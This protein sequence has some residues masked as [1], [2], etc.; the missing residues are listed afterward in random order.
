VANTLEIVIKGTDQASGTFDAITGRARGFSSGLQSSLRG[1]MVAGG[2]V[3]GA[4]AGIGVAAARAF[5]PT[6]E[7]AREFELAVVDMGIAADGTGLSLATLEDAAIAVGGDTSLL[8]V[9][10]SDAAEAI[11]GL[12]KA[13]LTSTEVF[14]DLQGYMAGTAELGGALRASIDLAA[15]TELDMVQASDLAAVA[16][17]TFG[18]ELETEE[19]RARFVEDAMNNL[20]Q[21][22]NA[23]V[24]SVS[25]L[26]ASMATAG[27]VFAMFGFD[28]EDTNNAL[29]ILSMRGI[30]GAE[31]GTALKSMLM[32]MTAQTDSTQE[33]WASLGLSM[34]DADGAMREL[35]DVIG[36]LNGAMADMTEEERNATMAALAGSYGIKA[37]STLLAEGEQGWRDMAQAT[38][39][40]MGITEQARLK[41]DTL[42]GAQEVLEGV[43][44]T[45]KIQ[46][47]QALLPALTT[48]AQT[49]AGLAEQYGPQ[50][51]AAMGAIGAWLGDNLP[52]VIA[53]AI[54]WFENLVASLTPVVAWIVAFVTE[55]GPMLQEAFIAI[56]AVLGAFLAAG[57][58]AAIAMAIAALVNPIGLIAAGIALLAVAWTRDW[59]G[60]R[61]TLTAFWNETAK[62]FIDNLV[63]WFQT[64]VPDA[65]A[66]V[67]D[68]FVTAWGNI[69]TA[70]QVV[71]Q[72]LVNIWNALST[73]F[74]VTIP[75]AGRSLWESLQRTLADIKEGFETVWNGIL[76]FLKSVWD[77]IR[78]AVLTAIILVLQLLGTNLDEIKAGWE[79][80]WNALRDH[81]TNI[82]NAIASTVETVFSAVKDFIGTTLDTLQST[83]ETVWGAV[84]AFADDTWDAIY[85]KASEIV[86]AVRAY[87]EEKVNAL[88][89]QWETAWGL[90]KDAAETAWNA[91]KTKVEEILPAIIAVVTEKAAELKAALIDPIIE[92]KDAI[93]EK[94]GEWAQLG[95]DLLEGLIGGVKEK[96]GG[97]IDSVKGAVGDAIQEAKNI[98]GIES[99]SKVF[100]EIGRNVVQ[101]MID[102]ILS[103]KGNLTSTINGLIDI[104]Q[105][106]GSLGGFAA[107][108]LKK[109]TVEPLAGTLEK[110]DERIAEMRE[111]LIESADAGDMYSWLAI[112]RELNTLLAERTR[113][114]EQFAEAEERVLRMEKQR[115]QLGFLQEQMKLLDFIKER[116]LDA[117]ALL[118]GVKLG[119]NADLGQII[120]VMSAAMQAVLESAENTLGIASPSKK[121][122]EIGRNIMQGLSHGIAGGAMQPIAD[123][124]MV[125][126]R[127]AQAAGTTVNNVYNLNANYAYQDERTLTQ[128][129][130]LLSM[131]GA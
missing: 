37:L 50:V 85:T 53:G 91:I 106:F 71:W 117:G 24:S 102:G 13:G 93:F 44:E 51:V 80:I 15:A 30:K 18:G 67:R 82:W 123:V 52:G 74:T 112:Q 57:S 113:L 31:A 47:G 84:S 55:H 14:A 87:V 27:P 76:G 94:V 108:L 122:A 86:E 116:G 107:S 98:L 5:G 36:D 109:R 95:R 119:I 9:T 79:F 103:G 114:G 124:A 28:L 64:T 125:G 38:A 40:A 4:I 6:I 34:Y 81:V 48:L 54:A 41:V 33:A 43:M 45:L 60:I 130:R 1:A 20:V 121:F 42:A 58:L 96:V 78:V 39:D 70:V 8:G 68:W 75:T 32:N 104:G 73:V 77:G 90:V 46:I 3:A 16:L 59:G 65:L 11:T 97:L 23:S 7:L 12:F 115:D 21:A 2:L 72:R 99:P 17:S 110:M 49:F 89:T 35:P 26:A 25:D 22:A 111:A 83:W 101:G 88:K 126:N 10:A 120:D 69:Q 56:A 129:V 105:A 118:D 63:L 92:A 131:L 127:M 29:A 61:T 62:P 100:A 19:E 66:A 128:D